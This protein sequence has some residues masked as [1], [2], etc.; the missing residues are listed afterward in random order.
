MMGFTFETEDTTKGIQALIS[1]GSTDCQELVIADI[2]VSNKNRNI[3]FRQKGK[4]ER[5]YI[6]KTNFSPKIGETY[7]IVMV[8][9]Q[10]DVAF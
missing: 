4:T 5:Q 6:F 3:V 7:H 2:G 8:Y 9:S 10:G 1:H